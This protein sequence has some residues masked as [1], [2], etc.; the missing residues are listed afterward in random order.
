MED[1]TT[2]AAAITAVAARWAKTAS[3]MVMVMVMVTVF[4]TA[5]MVSTASTC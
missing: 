1:A 5:V 2:T 4:A 3:M